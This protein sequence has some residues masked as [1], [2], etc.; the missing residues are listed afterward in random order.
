M[1]QEMIP[2]T[3]FMGLTVVLCLYFWVRFRTRSEMQTTI[4]TAIDKGQELSPEIIDRLG[5]P[6]RPKDQDLRIALVYLAIALS[7]AV[8]GFMIPE[9]KDEVERVFMGIAAFPF[10]TSMAYL[11]M[12]RFT[13]KPS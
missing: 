8:F 9:D 1:N 13:D 2:I 6:K 4:R 3:L 11:I 10:F 12:Y 7:L 5:S